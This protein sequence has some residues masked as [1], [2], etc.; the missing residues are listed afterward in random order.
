MVEF[1]IVVTLIYRQ[2]IL[3]GTK[4]R[5]ILIWRVLEEIL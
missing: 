3:S 4:F 5:C 1:D 2:F